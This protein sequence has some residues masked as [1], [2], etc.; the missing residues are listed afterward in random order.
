MSLLQE[1]SLADRRRAAMALDAYHEALRE[2]P[3]HF[4]ERLGFFVCGRYALIASSAAR[5]RRTFPPPAS[6]AKR[7]DGLRPAHHPESR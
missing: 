3:V 4:D 1:K 7:V 5:Q 6:T 2:R